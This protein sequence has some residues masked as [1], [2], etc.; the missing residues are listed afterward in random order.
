MNRLVALTLVLTAGVLTT[1][2]GAQAPK[3]VWSPT[4]T[5]TNAGG[6]NNTIPLWSMSATYQQVLDA[7]DFTSGVVQMKGL[8]MRPHAT[9]TLTGRSWDMRITLSHTKKT[10]ATASST[11]SANLVGTS[12]TVVFGTP[13]TFSRFS[14]NTVTGTG[15]VNPPAFTIPFSSPYTYIPSLGN[16]C[17]EWRHKNATT[18]QNNSVDATFGATQRGTILAKVGRGC[19]VRGNTAPA[20]PIISIVGSGNASYSFRSVLVNATTNSN[21]IMALGVT[22]KTQNLGWCTAVELVP[23][24][25][26]YGKTDAGGS[27]TFY[28]PLSLLA[29]APALNVYVQYVFDDPSQT[30]GLGLSDMA[31]Y[32]T[33]NVPGAHAVCRIYTPGS[34]ANGSELL[35]SGTV[36]RNYGLVVGWLQ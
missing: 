15:P 31:G 28:A 19:T 25:F 20:T 1:T 30:A 35:S 34:A 9:K 36:S 26:I 7:N 24:A 18:N 21:A 22:P 3:Y 6:N 11:F 29:G 4:G 12:T 8:A 14:W 33:A 23:A 5:A 13:T 16:L 32:K 10:A 17:W 2:V 27:W